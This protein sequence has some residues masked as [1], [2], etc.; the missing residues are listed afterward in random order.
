MTAL[1]KCLQNQLNIQGSYRSV[2]LNVGSLLFKTKQEVF[3]K[4]NPRSFTATPN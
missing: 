3:M 1:L 2:P 4:Y